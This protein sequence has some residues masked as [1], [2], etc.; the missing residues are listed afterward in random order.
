MLSPG[1]VQAAA[2]ERQRLENHRQQHQQQQQQQQRQP[3]C[4]VPSSA[5][6]RQTQTEQQQHGAAVSIEAPAQQQQNSTSFDAVV[7]SNSSMLTVRQ[8]TVLREVGDANPTSMA[9]VPTNPDASDQAC[10]N[11]RQCVDGPTE[12]QHRSC[13]H[14]GANPAA[15][16]GPVEHQNTD[17]GPPEEGGTAHQ[18]QRQLLLAAAAALPTANK[19]DV[20]CSA[21]NSSNAGMFAAGVSAGITPQRLG[22]A[23]PAQPAADLVEITPVGAVTGLHPT[24]MGWSANIRSHR[25]AAPASAGICEQQQQQQRGEV[26][27][28]DGSWLGAAG[29]AAAA[30]AWMAQQPSSVTL[31]MDEWIEWYV[32]SKQQRQHL[33]QRQGTAPLQACEGAGPCVESQSLH[34]QQQQQQ[35]LYPVYPMSQSPTDHQLWWWSHWGDPGPPQNTQQH[36]AAAE[37]V[38]IMDRPEQQQVRQQGQ[39]L[40]APTRR[41]KHHIAKQTAAS[42]A[43]TAAAAAGI[44]ALP[45]A[46]SA[47]ASAA[48]AATAQGHAASSKKPPAQ[49]KQ[50]TLAVPN[51]NLLSSTQ[52]LLAATASVAHESSSNSSTGCELCGVLL[53]PVLTAV[54][55]GFP[56]NGTYFQVHEMFVDQRSL[57]QPLL[58]PQTLVHTIWQQLAAAD[59]GTTGINSSSRTVDAAAAAQQQAATTSKPDISVPMLQWTPVCLGSSASSICSGMGTAELTSFFQA[60]RMCIRSY[61]PATG[62]VSLKLPAYLAP[63]GNAG[64]V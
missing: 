37:Q 23:D 5:A 49:Q 45:T 16:R 58:L 54:R 15:S 53:V 13:S 27:A 62:G 41:R 52:E 57:L 17:T 7:S 34:W 22:A 25:A 56:L 4:P 48:A 3:A 2:A 33:L 21:D 39:T 26:Q 6:I 11:Y 46:A 63:A 19:P 1:S 35:W 60:G 20:Q 18:H 61:D 50:V 12:Q 14:S 38:R 36:T 55:G 47:V 59:C 42:T 30:A 28:G 9:A 24:P 31:T 64:S 32:Y 8:L 43:R 51:C 44:A 40:P 29:T 10:A